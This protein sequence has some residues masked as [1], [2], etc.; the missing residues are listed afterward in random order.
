MDAEFATAGTTT[1][2][3]VQ[4][5]LFDIPRTLSYLNCAN[6]SPQ[7]RSVTAIGV[8]AVHGKTA[9]WA[10]RPEDWFVRSE[11]LRALFAEI[12][13]ADAEGVALVPSVSYGIAVAAANLP[14]RAGQSIVLLDGEFPSNVYAWRELARRQ[15]A[16]IRTVTRETNETWTDRVIEAIGENTAV[17]S[18]PNCHWTDGRLVDLARVAAAARSVGASLVV[19]ASQS[20][21]AYPLDVSAIR[22]DFLATVG[23]KWLLGPYGLGY[24]YVAPRWREAGIPL[25]QSWLTRAGAEDFT[26]LSDYT[27]SYRQGARRFDMGEFPQFVLTP[28]AIAALE[29][30]LTWGVD[31]IQKTVARLA[32]QAE[33]GAIEIG[34]TAV[35][36]NDRV[37]HIIGIRPDAGVRPQLVAALTAANVYVSVRGDALRVAPHVYNETAD[38]T[39]LLA[40]LREDARAS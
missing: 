15:G 29:Q 32:A 14:V 35:P 21:G 2:L 17:V 40:V 37:G 30:V 6:M 8:A 16:N 33:H 23:Y 4:R 22:P 39:R 1:P 28:M 5:E 34:A 25:E 38:I 3:A 27:D 24:L 11:R 12:V 13:N 9:P 36:E 19:D 10:I 18:V 26:Q 20:A 7:L 31:H